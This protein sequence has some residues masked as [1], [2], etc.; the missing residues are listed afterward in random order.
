TVDSVTT[1]RIKILGEVALR[2][3]GQQPVSYVEGMQTLDIVEAYTEKAGGRRITVDPASI[4]TRDEA[5]G[6][7][8][9]YQRD[10]KERTVIFP[11]LAVGD[12]IVLTTRIETKAG[13]FPGH[14]FHNV[15]FSPQ[16]PWADSIVRIVVPKGLAVNVAALGDGIEDR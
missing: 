8:A 3:V 2:S 12:T 14:Y 6:L 13:V 1:T 5:S 16:I 11:D 15:V 4:I 9:V 10:A 7:N